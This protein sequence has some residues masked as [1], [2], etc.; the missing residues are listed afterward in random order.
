MALPTLAFFDLAGCE[1]C[2]L[3]IANMGET[4]L[5]LLK[6]VQLVEFREISSE[7]WTGP[8]ALA[9]VEGSVVTAEAGQRLREIRERSGL[10]IALGSCAV[11]GGLNGL[12]NRQ[13]PE[14]V[15]RSVYGDQPCFVATSAV[16]PLQQIVKVDY[17][18]PGCPI[19]PEEFVKVIKAALAGL[20]C[21][22]P[23]YAVCVE[24]KFNENVCRYD[25][26]V[27]CLG[28]ITRAGCNSWCINHGNTCYGCRGK[29]SNP[30]CAG[31]SEVLSRYGLDADRLLEKMCMYDAA[32][33]G[34]DDD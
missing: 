23:D 30:N 1:G 20:P 4:L 10:L 12:K 21:P 2:Q 8:L 19:F 29:V 34:G 16:R 6:K 27:T 13:R 18:V 5:A 3:Q 9:V 33:G 15:Q 22:V 11:T 31:A 28:P 17:Q 14:E 7:R 26:G 32:A 25:K 24:C